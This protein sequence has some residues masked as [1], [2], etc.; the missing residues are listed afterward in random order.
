MEITSQLKESIATEIGQLLEEP[1]EDGRLVL[2]GDRGF[3]VI[4]SD[5]TDKHIILYAAAGRALDRS[6]DKEE[7]ELLYQSGFR[8]RS[9]ARSYQR[10]CA[11]PDQIALDELAREVISVMNS[12]YVSA[13]EEIKLMT[14]SMSRVDLSNTRLI[15]SMRRLS[16]QRDMSARQKLY[17]ALIKSDVLLALRSPIPQVLTREAGRLQWVEAG[18]R[19]PAEI[20]ETIE[21]MSFKEV[22]GYRSAAVFTDYELLDQLDP[23]G[24]NY[25]RLPGR[26]AIML[27]L[28]KKWDSLLINPRG[29]VGGELYRNELTS[30]SEGLKQLGW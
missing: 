17:W 10:R 30:I 18:I 4:R 15:Q 28:H 1:E 13:D 27:A 12:L 3:M 8:R 14:R 2:Q 20:S 25:V 29:E 23:R 26:L 6:L 22:T 5:G 11:L 19:E 9:A 21:M 24:V 7:A 16:E